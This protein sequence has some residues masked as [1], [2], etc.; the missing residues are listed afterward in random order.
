M[1]S[2]EELTDRQLRY[3]GVSLGLMLFVFAGGAH[4]K[5]N[6]SGFALV[7]VATTITLMTVYYAVP[8]TRQTVFRGFKLLT[9]PIRMV[10]TMLILAIIYYFVVTPIGIGLRLA[11]KSIRR[12]PSTDKTQSY[13]VERSA[14]QKVSRYFDTF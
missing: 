2:D 5:W 10:A 12:Y 14:E 1:F 8:R 4:W 11:G 7:L 6:A 9:F 13:W 3:F